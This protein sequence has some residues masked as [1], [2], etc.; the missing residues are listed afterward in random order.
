MIG[1][2]SIFCDLS[3]PTRRASRRVRLKSIAS[4]ATRSLEGGSI[5]RSIELDQKAENIPVGAAK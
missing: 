3:L 4:N 5:D 2:L 1:H